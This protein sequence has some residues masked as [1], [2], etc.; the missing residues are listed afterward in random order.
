MF[1]TYFKI[2][3][4]FIIFEIR[5]DILTTKKNTYNTINFQTAQFESALDRGHLSYIN[6]LANN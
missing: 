3:V 5:V 2:K 6:Q 4:E 1:Y